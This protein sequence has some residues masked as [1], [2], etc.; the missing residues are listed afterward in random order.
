[1]EGVNKR[2][3][4]TPEAR[5][6]AALV[7]ESEQ[8]YR[9]PENWCW[10]RLLNSFENNTDG[11]KKVFRKAYLESGVLAVVD[12]GRELIGGYTNDAQMVYSG[13]LPVIIFGDHT[14]C[15][16]Y[17]D[18]P[19]AQGADGVKV[20]K[21]S[22]FFVPK[23][24][25]FALQSINIPDMGYRRHF[26][27]F[28]QYAL[29]LPPFPEQQ[30]IVARIESMFSRLD[31]ARQK[32]Q[33]ALD[34]F[35]TRKTAILHRAFNGQLTVQWRKEQGVGMDSWENRKLA[36]IAKEIKAG[37]DKPDDFTETI[38]DIHNVPVA[39]NGVTD[40]GII[41][42]TASARFSGETVTVAGRGTIGFSVC[43][44]Y[45]FFPVVRLVVI[46]PEDCVKA[47]YI[48]YAFDAFPEKGTGSSIPQLTVPMVKEK[49]IPVPK[50]SEQEEI[51]R[52]LDRLFAKEQ[53]T[54]E[55]AE[56]M[57]EKIRLVKKSILARAF[58]GGLGTNE[59]GEE[60]AAE[61]IKQTF[62]ETIDIHKV[63]KPK[64]KIKTEVELM[65]KTIMEALSNGVQLTPEKLKLET[66]LQIDDFYEQLKELIDQ[67]K[68]IE[69]RVDGDSCL[70]AANEDR[71]VENRAL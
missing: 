70:E 15:I 61:L 40:E 24:F 8:P 67:G 41:G 3:A 18:F 27:L 52:I 55:A 54:K 44:S 48:K 13:D 20:L 42:Y 16:K 51:V 38:D 12:Q 71:Q 43:R 59:P 56:N 53:R 11:K 14:R 5:L 21:P 45:P 6:Q 17:I 63:S 57:L 26:P 36:Q 30:R 39:A 35:E 34:S 33:D 58:R 10:V 65:P 60:S 23:A 4:L 62:L 37:G 47:E 64:R 49:I 66:K 50:I 29:P 22:P 69:T 46:V 28:G 2:E 25:Y 68:V 1:M 7:P 31:E 19:F 9:V 32:A